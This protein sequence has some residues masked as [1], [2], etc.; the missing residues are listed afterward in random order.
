MSDNEKIVND[1]NKKI[2]DFAKVLIKESLLV[3]SD[4]TKVSQVLSSKELGKWIF[5]AEVIKN[6]V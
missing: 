6:G 1:F 2:E 3:N 4:K 5:K